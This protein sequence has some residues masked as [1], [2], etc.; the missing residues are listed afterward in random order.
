ME[1]ITRVR[2]LT[3]AWLRRCSDDRCG[4]ESC[5]ACHT[6]SRACRAKPCTVGDCERLGALSIRGSVHSERTKSFFL[7]ERRMLVARAWLMPRV[8]RLRRSTVMRDKSEVAS[9]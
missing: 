5:P 8:A 3:R 2:V 1:G 4:S 9:R 7:P 6:R